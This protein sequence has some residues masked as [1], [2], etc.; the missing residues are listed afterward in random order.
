[1]TL[2]DLRQRFP[3]G[4][5]LYAFDPGAP[6]TLEVHAA[7]GVMLTYKAAT[8]AAAIIAFLAD[9]APPAPPAEPQPVSETESAGDVFD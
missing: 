5:A 1:M 4:F 7:N 6:V 9:I 2:D 3:H 8:E